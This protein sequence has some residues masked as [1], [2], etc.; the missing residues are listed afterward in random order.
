[1][2]LAVPGFMTM[3]PFAS[4]GFLPLVA[5]TTLLSLLTGASATEHDAC[6]PT[7]EI[8]IGIPYTCPYNNFVDG[9]CLTPEQI[10]DQTVQA[11][12]VDFDVEAARSLLAD[13]YIQ[14][15]PTVPT[16]AAPVLEFIPILKA[17]GL[18]IETHRTIKEGN[19]V[20]YHSTY[21]NATLFGGETLIGF[22]VFRVENGKVQE[23]WDNLQELAGPN[24]NGNTMVDGPT[25]IKYLGET[26]TNKEIA[27]ALVNGVLVQGNASVAPL[28]ISSESYTQHNPS[29]ADGLDGLAAALE[30]LAA[31]NLSFAY[32][33]VELVVAEGNFVLTG[34]P[35]EFGAGNPTAYYDLFRLENGLI[36]EHWDVIQPIPPA[37]EFAHDNGKF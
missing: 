23:H 10:A 33:S 22:D 31:Q 28:Y 16:G 6:T 19:L 15:N 9:V 35:G 14:H 17:S 30:N 3:S 25:M 1:M 8:E 29:I 13:D 37:S 7:M 36:V 5:T 34:S 24:P 2:N 21:T 20:A 4:G 32:D 26:E 12:F 18:A 27:L 11:L